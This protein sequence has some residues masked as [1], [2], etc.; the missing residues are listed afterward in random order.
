MYALFIALFALAAAITGYFQM[1]WDDPVSAHNYSSITAK[2]VA[3]NVLNYTSVVKQYAES[4]NITN[5]TISDSQIQS[6]LS[7]NFTKLGDYSSAVIT[8]DENTYEIVTWNSIYPSNTTNDTVVGELISLTSKVRATNGTS[9]VI[10]LIV[11]N[12]N[13]TGMIA[14]Q[15]LG[16][17][18]NNV[19]GYQQLFSNI[20]Q[21]SLPNNF[22]LGKYN[23][24]VQVI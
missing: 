9:W 24:V 1:R 11:I 15:H 13:C 10:P 16:L 23:I 4:Q 7:Y 14:N 21:S 3:E 19:T 20:C 22:K 5:Q 2:E 18:Q 17:M 12:Q 8:Y 6:V